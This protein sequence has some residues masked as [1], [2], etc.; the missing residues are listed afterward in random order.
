M[1]K[2]VSLSVVPFAA[3][4]L[5]AC[6][7]DSKAVNG[8]PFSTD[9]PTVT[10]IS[11]AMGPVTGG[12][13]VTILGTNFVDIASV[14]IGGNTASGFTVVNSTQIFASTPPATHGGGVDVVVTSSNHGWGTCGGC[15]VYHVT[16]SNNQITAGWDHT[17][18]LTKTGVAYCW[19]DNSHGE[20]GNGTTTNSSTP[21]PVS[22][23]L[24]FTSIAA[25]GWHTCAITDGKDVYCWGLNDAGQLGQGGGAQ[26]VFSS[27]PIQ[28]P[29]L[30][31]VT[32]VSTLNHTC[33]LADYGAARC[34]GANTHGELGVGST[35]NSPF[36]SQPQGIATFASIDA[37]GYHTCG[38]TAF[39]VFCWGL[40]ESGQLGN[41]LQGANLYAVTPSV[42]LAGGVAVF[43]GLYHS[44]VI[45]GSGG[46]G[47]TNAGV[48]SCW[49]TNL[50]GGLGVGSGSALD[51]CS[52]SPNT[53]DC[54]VRPVSVAGGHYFQTLSL[55]G[56]FT[57][58]I[59]NL[60][61]AWCWGAN[62]AG[63]LGNGST[64]QANFPMAVSGGFTFANITAA[65]T[66]Y[67]CGITTTGVAYCWG[68][69]DLGQLGNGTTTDSSIPVAVSGLPQL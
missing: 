57:C 6:G 40:D 59:D 53:G 2:I 64:T 49:G 43:T 58:G 51:H 62:E 28:V 61:A 1:V 5:A 41:G 65:T 22:G 44:C 7:S 42:A 26:P 29:V 23:G 36:P 67:A 16:S 46:S 4:V 18:A 66:N 25:G 69:N 37:G 39:T 10:S 11:P 47:V 8:P 48:A 33:G 55:G 13:T 9:P 60:G 68:K 63:Q 32:L 50:F 19:G 17:C 45:G 56:Y 15:F 38:I 52:T 30:Q 54:S 27:V 31:L 35:A 24:H 21:V 34:W 12:T 20:L 14:T 3:L